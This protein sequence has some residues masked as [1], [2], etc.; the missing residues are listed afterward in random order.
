MT[1]ALVC[2]A[3]KRL[4]EA[5][6]IAASKVAN[7]REARRLRVMIAAEHYRYVTEERIELLNS[8][9]RRKTENRGMAWFGPSHVYSKIKYSSI[10]VYPEVPPA[11][12]L[13]SFEQAKTWGCFDAFGVLYLAA[14]K[15][16]KPAR[17]DP[18]LVGAIQ[19]L[20][21]YFAID[22]WGSDIEL[23]DLLRMIEQG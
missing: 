7:D 16:E 1:T 2:Q 22:Q 17:T 14:I 8:L 20:P 23:P 5:G 3:G 12:V 18:L 13:E 19:G 6:W 10:S 4:V 11:S 21:V 9:V 15:D